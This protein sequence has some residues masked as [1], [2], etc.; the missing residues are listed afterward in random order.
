MGIL[1]HRAL[2]GSPFVSLV[3]AALVVGAALVSYPTHKP[4]RQL[5]I[6]FFTRAVPALEGFLPAVCRRVQFSLKLVDA[7]RTPVVFTAVLFD[8]QVQF[9]AFFNWKTT[10][11]AARHLK[12]ST[13]KL[14]SGR[15]SSALNKALRVVTHN[16]LQLLLRTH[17]L[18]VEWVGLSRLDLHA[19][20]HFG[21]LVGLTSLLLLS[22]AACNLVLTQSMLH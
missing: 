2:G 22:R 6:H 20:A 15:V 9:A 10:L 21:V 8:K 14:G 16:W 7:L 5:N 3:V 1:A 4:I 12:V 11:L 19:L 17:V 13:A 18:L